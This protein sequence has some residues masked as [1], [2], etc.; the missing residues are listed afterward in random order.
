[1]ERFSHDHLTLTNACSNLPRKARDRRFARTSGHLKSRFATSA[2]HP[3]S[4]PSSTLSLLALLAPHCWHCIEPVAGIGS[5]SGF[6]RPYR[7]T[8]AHISTRAL[9][10]LWDE[11]DSIGTRDTVMLDDHR[12]EAVFLKNLEVRFAKDLIYVS[13]VCQFTTTPYL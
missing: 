10:D 13:G 7:T 6:S 1:M 9:G 12:S 8:A 3:V 4:T 5:S 2:M 11:Q